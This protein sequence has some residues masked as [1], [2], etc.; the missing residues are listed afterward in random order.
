MNIKLNFLEL[1]ETNNWFYK[2]VGAMDELSERDI[3]CDYQYYIDELKDISK[4]L[5][6]E[7]MFDW[8]EIYKLYE[9]NDDEYMDLLVDTEN[10]I[11]EILK[12]AI[13]GIKDRR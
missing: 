3:D 13:Y 12:S 9:D 2:Y 11:A 8:D 6:I 7:N 4:K 1:Y 5:G 10:K